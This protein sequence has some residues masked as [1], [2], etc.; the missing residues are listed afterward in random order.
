[1]LCSAYTENREQLIAIHPLCASHNLLDAYFISIVPL[2]TEE[3]SFAQPLCGH[4]SLF[5]FP[6]LS[7][8]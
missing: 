7:A 2:Q 6:S 4:C 3:T 1:M 8:P 5:L